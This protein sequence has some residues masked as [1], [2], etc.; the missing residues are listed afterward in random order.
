MHSVSGYTTV[1]LWIII[2]GLV[3]SLIPSSKLPLWR[4]R[5]GGRVN[6]DKGTL[7]FG[8]LIKHPEHLLKPET[9]CKSRLFSAKSARQSLPVCEDTQTHD[10]S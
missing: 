4:R 9:L 2:R 6:T 8:N 7:E 5:E 3:G 1:P 10:V